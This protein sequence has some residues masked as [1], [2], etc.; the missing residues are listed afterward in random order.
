M[1]SEA[2]QISVPHRLWTRQKP[3]TSKCLRW[4]SMQDHWHVPFYVCLFLVLICSHP[5]LTRWKCFI[6]SH[7]QV[8][9]WGCRIHNSTQGTGNT[10]N[11]IPLLSE[12]AA[13]F[14]FVA[15]ARLVVAWLWIVKICPKL[16]VIGLEHVAFHF[17]R[18]PFC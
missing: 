15:Q 5:L 17:L 2:E 10:L 8:I 6:F 13:S 11:S 16:T 3:W 18:N 1:F 9:Y 7:F 12:T 4:V 14:V